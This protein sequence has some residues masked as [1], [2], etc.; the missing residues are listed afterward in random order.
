MIARIGRIFAQSS[1]AVRSLKL[2]TFF[3]VLSVAL[4]I[5][6]ITVIVA[7]V[8]GAY[9][10]AHEMVSRFGYDAVIVFGGDEQLR[11]AGARMKTMTLDDV[12]AI[13]SAVPT[14]Y[15]VVPMV[16]ARSVS[17][18]Y[19]DKK[20]QTQVIGSTSDYS[21]AWSWPVV[22]GSD[23]DEEHVKGVHNVVMLGAHLVRELFGDEDAIGKYILIKGIPVKVIA[24][25]EERGTSGMGDNLDDRAIMP[26]TT[27]MRKIQNE[28]K[29]ITG[30]RVR[31]VDPE[32]MSVHVDEVKAA[33]RRSHRLGPQEPDDFRAVSSQEITKFLVALTGSLVLFLGIVGMISL[34]VAGFVLANLFLLSVKERT[35]EIGIRR[36]AGAKK[37]DILMQFLFEAVLITS[38]GGVAGFFL[39]YLSSKLLVLVSPFPLYF[40][41]K[42]F[43]VGLVLSWA[44][45][46]GF[47]L[48]PA[49]R[50]SEL[51]V[52][53]ALKE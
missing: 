16:S 20:T 43:A 15:L 52:I 23:L 11:A 14:S 7:A 21:R 25:L 29:F 5:A 48:Q 45:G 39:G 18:S 44:V 46:I 36:A 6:S 41:W 3:C 13:R 4:G 40:S 33:L 47:G 26:V 37:R 42:A 35:K 19:K 31:V 8:E 50:A 51:K 24:T 10:K 17:I 1:V 49:K 34:V 30:V 27:V 22:A 38:I 12:E 32:N 2:R 28:P 53:E 9:Q